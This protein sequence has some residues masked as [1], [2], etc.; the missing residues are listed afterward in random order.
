MIVGNELVETLHDEIFITIRSK[1]GVSDEF[2]LTNFDF[3]NLHEGGGKG[4]SL[5][6]RSTCGNFFVKE[7][8]ISDKHTMLNGNFCELYAERVL[9]NDSL[10]C[11]IFCVFTRRIDG[12]YYIAMGNCIP[13]CEK[14]WDLIYDLKGTAD[15]K[16]LVRNGKIV[17]E[18]HKR[19]WRLDWMFLEAFGKVSKKRVRY[20]EGKRGAYTSS[21]ILT[22]EQKREIMLMIKRDLQFFIKQ[23]LMDYSMIVAIKQVDKMYATIP[24][25]NTK[26]CMNMYNSFKVWHGDKL[27]IVYVGIIDF[28]QGWTT[29][30]RVAHI[31]KCIFA[32]KPISTVHPVIYAE[33]FE[34]FF[35][36]KFSTEEHTR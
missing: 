2:L 1:F 26:P 19:F 23:D 13:A 12:K 36:K 21:I 33:Q 18:V 34:K 31:I 17:D 32:P 22:S 27:Y 4:G 16:T 14:S 20:V 15:D 10:L 8:S 25:E 24:F 29:G 7:L 3:G 30:K 35:E 9:S 6:S 11:R 5:L 28:L